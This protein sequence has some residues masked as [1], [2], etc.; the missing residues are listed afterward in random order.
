M[1][2]P[3][4]SQ[5][6]SPGID[7]LLFLAASSSPAVLDTHLTP[8]GLVHRPERASHCSQQLFSTSQYFEDLEIGREISLAKSRQINLSSSA[9]LSA[10]PPSSLVV[11]AAAA[12][13]SIPTGQW[14]CYCFA[15]SPCALPSSDRFSDIPPATTTASD[16][17]LD[18][19]SEIQKHTR[20]FLRHGHLIGSTGDE[21]G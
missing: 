12:Q 1:R 20:S 3:S 11:R 14:Y 19:T 4:F 13:E 17:P 2:C 21:I 6:A 15:S 9:P 18:T 7:L 16:F 5:P 10:N 8:A